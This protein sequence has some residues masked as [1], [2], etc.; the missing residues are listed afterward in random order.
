[1][2]DALLDLFL[3]IFASFT[4]DLVWHHFQHVIFLEVGHLARVVKACMMVVS[5]NAAIHRVIDA[6]PD[7]VVVHRHSIWVVHGARLANL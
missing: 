4:L 6:G 5:T 3:M 7:R 2:L 1:M